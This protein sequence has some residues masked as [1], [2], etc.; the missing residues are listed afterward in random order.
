MYKRSRNFFTWPEIAWNEQIQLFRKSIDIDNNSADQ[1][2]FKKKKEIKRKIDRER[3]I[4]AFSSLLAHLNCK[5]IFLEIP[6]R[7]WSQ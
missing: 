1:T 2:L 3:I 5:H 4:I 7:D 6:K